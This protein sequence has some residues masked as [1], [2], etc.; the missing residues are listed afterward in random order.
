MKAL[1]LSKSTPRKS[2]RNKLFVVDALREEGFDVLHATVCGSLSRARPRNAGD[3]RDE[4]LTRRT[5]PG[6][7]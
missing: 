1:S 2:Q 5:L 4:L 7:G 3:L 6:A